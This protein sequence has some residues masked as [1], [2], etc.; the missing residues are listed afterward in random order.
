MMGI[1]LGLAWDPRCGP[2]GSQPNP[3]KETLHQCLVKIVGHTKH[4]NDLAV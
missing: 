2:L 3:T 4:W 1:L